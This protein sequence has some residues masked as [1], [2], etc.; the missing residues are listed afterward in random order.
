MKSSVTFF[1]ILIWIVCPLT[2]TTA[3][4]FG[5]AD[6]VYRVTGS[7]GVAGLGECSA[8]DPQGLLRAADKALYLAKA[9]GRN[10]VAVMHGDN[11]VAVVG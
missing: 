11:P 2:G 5:D 1:L 4:V 6:D 10:R 8:E 7:F 3:G 9:M